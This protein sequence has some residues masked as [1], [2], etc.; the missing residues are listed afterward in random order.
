MGK[1]IPQEYWE[2]QLQ[3]GYKNHTVYMHDGSGHHFNRLN[4]N[5]SLINIINKRLL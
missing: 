1:N 5:Y 3:Y 4:V 2:I